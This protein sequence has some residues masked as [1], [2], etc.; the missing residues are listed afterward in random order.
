MLKDLF[1]LHENVFQVSHA[2][3]GE[4]GHS[5]SQSAMLIEQMLGT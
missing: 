5:G 4:K 1:F 2:E 3:M